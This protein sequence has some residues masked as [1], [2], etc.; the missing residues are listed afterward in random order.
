MVFMPLV[1]HRSGPFL[2][3][4]HDIWRQPPFPGDRHDS[5][6]FRVTTRSITK[7]AAASW[8]PH[9][10]RE[11]ELILALDGTLGVWAQNRFWPV[12]AGSALWIPAGISHSVHLAGAGRFI[13]GWMQD[14]DIAARPDALTGLALPAVARELLLA[15]AALDAKEDTL[16]LATRQR[17]EACFLDFMAHAEPRPLELPL[18]TDRRLLRVT[19]A[20]LADPSDNRTMDAW[21]LLAGMSLRSFTRHFAEATGLGFRQWRLLARMIWAHSLLES[22][23]TLDCVA[24]SCGYGSSGA[25]ATAYRRVTGMA[26]EPVQI[27]RSARQNDRSNRAYAL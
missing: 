23:M 15:I 7:A 24:R 6:Q 10:D 17:A 18:P 9:I 14:D 13:C 3:Q 11:H 20:I 21:C 22:G 26:P 4:M 5:R 8:P 2:T 25:F 1:T 27:G 19:E 12:T 16:P